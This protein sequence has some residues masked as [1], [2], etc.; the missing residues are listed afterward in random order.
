[1]A[2]DIHHK[3]VVSWNLSIIFI[4]E[5]I[6]IDSIKENNKLSSYEKSIIERTM[7]Y[8]K[9]IEQKFWWLFSTS[10]EEMQTKACKELVNSVC[11]FPQQRKYALSEQS[12]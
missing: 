7:Q 6:L 3:P 11:K 4:S 9:R 5:K 2:H 1:V 12:Q 10:N 8:I